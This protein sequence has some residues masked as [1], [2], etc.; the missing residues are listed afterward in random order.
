MTWSF[1]YENLKQKHKLLPPTA[2]LGLSVH[3]YHS[4]FCKDAALKLCKN[5]VIAMYTSCFSDNL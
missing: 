2:V 3:K 1:S 4:N 5:Q